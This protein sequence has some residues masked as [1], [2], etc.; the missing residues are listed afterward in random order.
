MSNAYARRIRLNPIWGFSEETQYVT[1][2]YETARYQY[3]ETTYRVAAIPFV[4]VEWK[5]HNGV[6]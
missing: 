1:R 3:S 6:A 2:K 4:A 5:K